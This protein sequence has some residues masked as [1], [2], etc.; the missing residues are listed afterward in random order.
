M[1]F[2]NVIEYSVFIVRPFGFFLVAARVY[3]AMAHGLGGSYHTSERAKTGWNDIEITAVVYAVGGPSL[4]ITPY[5]ACRLE[6]SISR[7]CGTRQRLFQFQ[8]HPRPMYNTAHN[9]SSAVRWQT[10]LS[11]L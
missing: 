10:Q 4:V 3:V 11:H 1:F 7:I 2:K 8:T 5:S 9:K 6:F